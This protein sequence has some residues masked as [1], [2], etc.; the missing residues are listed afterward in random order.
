[1][2]IFMLLLRYNLMMNLVP[3][4]VISTCLIVL[5][6]GCILFQDDATEWNQQG[7]THHIMG[8][9]EEAVGAYDKAIAL[10]PDYVEAWRN[11]GLSLSLLG[12]GP[13][14]AEAFNHALLIN[15]QD[16]ETW[17]YRALA[18]NSTGNQSGALE[19]IDRAVSIP[20]RNRDEAV[21]LTQS[22]KFRG[23][24]FFAGGHLDEAN[25][26]YKKAHEVMMS[27]I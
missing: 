17:Y 13:E 5:S 22:W 7:E 26:S 6:A 11:K 15:P 18:L 23:D 24:L 21:T 19:S 4:L 20:A 1:M 2:V 16:M 3:L 8:R 27:T 12:R 9:Y 25:V 14:S 10:K